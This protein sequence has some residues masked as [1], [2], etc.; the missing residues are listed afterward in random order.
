MCQHVFNFP[1]EVKGNYNPDGQTLTGVCKF[2]GAKQKAYGIRW[3][4]EKEENA[5]EQRFFNM[6]KFDK[7][8]IT[9]YNKKR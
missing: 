4:I 7:S 1:A 8:S 9:C 5:L 6:P 2:C 3:M